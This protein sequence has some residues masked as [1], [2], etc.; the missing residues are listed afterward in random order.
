MLL[1]S[2]SRQ[3]EFEMEVER[4]R[5]DISTSPVPNQD[6]RLFVCSYDFVYS[7]LTTSF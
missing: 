1:N 7:N 5:D 3:V 6:V 2:D 4:Q